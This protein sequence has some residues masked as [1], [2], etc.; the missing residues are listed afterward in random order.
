MR[1][2]LTYSSLW[3][4]GVGKMGVVAT[5]KMLCS[6]QHA[7]HRSSDICASFS[8]FLPLP[9]PLC[10][11]PPHCMCVSV[12]VSLWGWGECVSAP[13]TAVPVI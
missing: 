6:S 5:M 2:T 13:G 3:E 4:D 12:S 9:L 1:L 10:S 11:P 7:V 8:F